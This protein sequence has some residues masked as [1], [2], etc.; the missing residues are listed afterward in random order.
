LVTDDLICSW[1]GLAPGEWP[2]DHYRLLGL[3][4]GESDVQLIEQHV[5]QRLDALRGYQ[6]RHPEHATEALNR[7][8]QAF[9]CLTE[10]AAKERYD[11]DLLGRPV[12]P[13]KWKINPPTMEVMPAAEPPP[14]PESAP[15]NGRG[16][17]TTLV[18]PPPL[19]PPAIEIQAATVTDPTP[20]PDTVVLS[21]PLPDPPPPVEKICPILEAARSPLARCGLG[22]RGA[23]MRR[24]RRTRELFETWGQAARYLGSVKRRTALKS[25]DEEKEFATVFARIAR[26]CR[27]FPRILGEA[28]QPGC[29]VLSLARRHPA[30]TYRSLEASQRDA[31][32]RDWQAG[33]DLLLAHRDFLREQAGELRLMTPKQRFGRAFRAFFTDQPRALS[34]LVVLAV[35]NAFLWSSWLSDHRK[36]SSHLPPDKASTQPWD[37]EK[38]KQ[39]AE[40][41][42]RDRRKVISVP[43]D[44]SQPQVEPNP[45]R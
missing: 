5:H 34:L 26:L 18:L 28:G 45:K 41:V 12:T 36:K 6:V 33:R 7:L 23:V 37:M 3:K 43:T 13:P 30:A 11:A 44:G 29:L 17:S 39:D 16:L 25:P 31:L 32:R 19:P 4:P 38:L 2:P 27:R 40:E 21:R 14:A 9:V 20:M 8:A 35:A 24:V 10:P 22:T 1:L 15:V 42:G